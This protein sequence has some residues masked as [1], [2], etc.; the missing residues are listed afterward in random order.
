MSI[1]FPI[2]F[3]PSNASEIRSFSRRALSQQLMISM[4]DE[5]PT[6][7]PATLSSL[8]GTVARIRIFICSIKLSAF[9]FSVCPERRKASSRTFIL[10]RTNSGRGPVVA[11]RFTLRLPLTTGSVAGHSVLWILSH[12]IA[13]S[14]DHPASNTED[15]SRSVETEGSK[16]V[17]SNDV[18]QSSD[19][20]LR[21]NFLLI[22]DNWIRSKFLVRY[23][24]KFKEEEARTFSIIASQV[25]LSDNS[26]I[27][28]HL[29]GAVNSSL[30]NLCRRFSIQSRT[31]GKVRSFPSSFLSK[32]WNVS[33][34]VLQPP[35]HPPGNSFHLYKNSHRKAS[36]SSY[37]RST[38][39]HCSHWSH[40]IQKKSPSS[41][42][43]L[44]IDVSL[45]SDSAF[46]SADPAERSS[47]SETW[48]GFSAYQ[49]LE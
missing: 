49:R 11:P 1:D 5:I 8:V 20:Y 28:F 43:S 30:G 12:L 10:S 44:A 31:I 40:L 17:V 4:R 3:F 27:A 18:S 45:M 15:K 26:R 14:N 33:G 41:P 35:C 36:L 21:G 29:T 16:A 48:K 25:V 38:F 7:N 19:R 23:H 32:A 47:I 34:L 39:R 13:S 2:P 37:C 24:V 6:S 9:S 22:R 42:P 46:S